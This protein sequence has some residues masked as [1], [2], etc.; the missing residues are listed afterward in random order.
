[1]TSAE[2]TAM[3]EIAVQLEQLTRGVGWEAMRYM[4]IARQ[5]DKLV[6]YCCP[7]HYAKVACQN[8]GHPEPHVGPAGFYNDVCAHSGCRCRLDSRGR[9]S[10]R[11]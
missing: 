6:E 5:I 2:E 11:D 3:H 1:M 9:A 4:A 8:C 7:T 10:S